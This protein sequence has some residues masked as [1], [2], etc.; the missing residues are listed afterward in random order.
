[1]GPTG[2]TVVSEYAGV[3][4]KLNVQAGAVVSA[5]SPLVDLI[6]DDGI[7]IRLGIEPE[8][9]GYLQ[10]GQPVILSS[11][12]RPASAS[13]SIRVISNA[14]DPATRLVD[15]LVSFPPLEGLPVR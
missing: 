8:D 13:G 7:E 12:I 11:V 9:V 10:I 15:A 3:V 5:G 2:R 6:R 1:M 14:V 4:D